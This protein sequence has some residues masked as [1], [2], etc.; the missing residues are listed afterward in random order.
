MAISE[1]HFVV[2]ADGNLFNGE[3][4]LDDEEDAFAH[5]EIQFTTEELQQ[6]EEQTLSPE[7]QKLCEQVQNGADAA[8]TELNNPAVDIFNEEL[9]LEHRRA[10]F[11]EIVRCMLLAAE[12]RGG[13]NME[14]KMVKLAK[15]IL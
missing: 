1:E 13:Y 4:Y 15:D 12:H 11:G 2:G 8:I 3:D 7:F 14:P 5:D 9:P 10:T 6:Y